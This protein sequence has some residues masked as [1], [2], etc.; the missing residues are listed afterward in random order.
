MNRY[1]YEHQNLVEL[2]RNEFREN[3]SSM[4]WL[5]PDEAD[6][7]LKERHFLLKELESSGALTGYSGTKLD[8][9]SLSPGCRICGEGTWSCLFIN[10]ICNSHCFYCP[11]PQDDIG[12]PTTNTV[13]FSSEKDYSDYIRIFGF[14]GI[15]ISGGEPLLSPKAAMNYIEAV[16]SSSGTNIHTWLY[17]NGKLVNPEILRSLRDAGLEEIRFDIGA[18]DY[19]LSKVEMAVKIIPVVTVEIPAIPEDFT[20]MKTIIWNMQEIGVK[21]LNLHQLRATPHN[22]RNLLKRD[23]TFI[24]GKRAT[25]LES[26]MTA[27]KLIRFARENAT[28][29]PVNYCSFVYKDRYQRFAARRRH[30]AY[31]CEGY[32]TITGAGFIRQLSV[33]GS[34]EYISS[35]A[36]TLTTAELGL[37]SW[38]MDAMKNAL[39]F[40]ADIA[41]LIDT[42]NVEISVRYFASAIRQENTH[43]FPSREIL[44]NPSKSVFIERSVMTEA[45]KMDSLQWGYFKELFLKN[46][47]S[48]LTNRLQERISYL[49]SLHPR[50][51]KNEPWYYILEYEHLKEGLGDYF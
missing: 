8:T 49:N 51:L 4:R 15:S 35:L 16:K 31:V 20:R 28:N 22:I 29:I 27:L 5:G 36:N 17:T 3:Y 18:I 2:N 9:E 40:N 19:D 42:E 37:S 30:A 24:H 48:Q 12:I 50:Q 26:E 41:H 1:E 32:E 47:E 11:T 45:L 46:G 38:K 23:Y 14:R 13:R 43:R 25:V 7:S 10:G 21:Y 44:L 34:P 6:N 33:T 39:Y